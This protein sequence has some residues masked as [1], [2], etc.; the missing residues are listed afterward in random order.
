MAIK[1]TSEEFFTKKLDESFEGLRGISQTFL[2]GGEAAAEKQFADFIRNGGIDT[3]AYFKNKPVSELTEALLAD[4]EKILDGWLCSCGVPLQFKGR[5][6]DW[7]ANPTYNKYSE[8]TWQL[9]RHP[10]WSK[11]AKLY[12]A[13]ED[14][15]Y[16]EALQDYLIGFVEQTERPELGTS[17]FQTLS[18]RT[19]ECGLRLEDVW[20]EVIMT[21]A[22]SK[23]LKDH[24][25]ACFFRSVWEQVDRIIDAPTTH[26]W[27]ISAMSGVDAAAIY[28]PFFTD[29]DEWARYSTGRLNDEFGVQIYDDG[30]QFELTTGY[31]LVVIGA[32]RRVISR[33]SAMGKPLSEE[34]CRNVASLYRVY[35]K[36]MMPDGKSPGLNDGGKIDVPKVSREAIDLMPDFR[37]EFEY[38]GEGIGKEPEFKSILMPY[39]GFAVMRS[40]WG[41]DDFCSILESAPF[42][43]AHQHEDKLQ[44]MLFAY[45]KRLLDDPGSF[46]YDTSDMR[47]YILS[48]YSHNTALVDG[49]GQNRRAR[50]Q[51]Q[52]EFIKKKADVKATF[53]ND[54][55]AAEGFY[56]QGYGEEFIPV[57]HERTLVWHKNGLGDIKIPFWTVYDKFIPADGKEHTYS[58]LWHLDEAE[59]KVSGNTVSAD[60][61]DG[62]SFEI[63]GMSAPRI[64]KG[65][66]EPVFM[67]W[68]P[69]HT[70]GDNPHY[71]IPTVN[72]DYKGG[73]VAAVTALVP[74]KEGMKNPIKSLEC[75]T[76]GNV[77]VITNE[78]KCSF[79]KNDLFD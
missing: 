52:A 20:P 11:L 69:N 67:G 60:F 39:S 37:P 27:L 68:K 31:H 5:A 63:V 47:K 57:R 71:P 77:T 56:D 62:V 3:E 22:K 73:T 61:G 70:P 36:L 23:T 32:Y 51:W 25:I 21:F 19:L 33:H 1:L 50:H 78:G 72:L 35:I 49:C 6:V 64:V 53:G 8:W 34:F 38:I 44:V 28:F 2:D 17:G 14:E 58:L 48:S 43:Y 55:E 16:A 10:E 66:T 29:S 76:E 13:T 79:N 4:G 15:K 41:S 7:T 54:A 26:N 42:G 59:E 74:L 12:R 18:W 45:G 65:Q 30:F 40:G 24:T 46:R 9:S 75:D